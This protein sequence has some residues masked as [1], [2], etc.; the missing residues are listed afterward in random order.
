V[1]EQLW[2]K[3]ENNENDLAVVKDSIVFGF[4]YCRRLIWHGKNAALAV[5]A[6]R[7]TFTPIKCFCYGTARYDDIIYSATKCITF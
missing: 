7:A 6:F 3:Q 5:T 4:K 2:L 1:G